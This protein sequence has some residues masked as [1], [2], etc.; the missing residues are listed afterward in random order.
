MQYSQHAFSDLDNPGFDIKTYSRLKFGSDIAARDLG[1][2]LADGL[3]AEHAA[4]LLANQCVII[5]SPYNIVENAA[6]KMSR[7][8][9]NKLNEHL[10]SANGRHAD[11]SLIHRKVSYIQDYG[12]LP[13]AEREKLIG[14]DMFFM[15]TEYLAGKLLILR[16]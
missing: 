6:T 8:F 3:F 2:E 15:N 7:H 10:V 4:L 12:F 14:N 1:Y 11:W 16:G 9:M 13:Q 5:P